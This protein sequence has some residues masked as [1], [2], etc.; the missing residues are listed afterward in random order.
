[1]RAKLPPHHPSASETRSASVN[2]TGT[3]C[4]DEREAQ[5]RVAAYGDLVIALRVGRDAVGR[6]L[7]YDRSADERCVA[8]VGQT[9]C[10][11]DAV[12]RLGRMNEQAQQHTWYILFYKIHI[13]PP[14][15]C[16]AGVV[17]FL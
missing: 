1:M 8:G 2:S 7:F 6:P 3:D 11:R 17:P 15:A 16:G 5:G 9:P 12:L 14:F 10:D 13:L 4:A